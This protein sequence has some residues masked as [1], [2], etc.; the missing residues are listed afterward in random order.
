MKTVRRILRYIKG[1]P[2][3]GLW[4]KSNGHLRIEDYCD[5]D[6]ASCVDDCRYMT[7]YCVRVRINLVAWRSK[8][9]DMVVRSSTEAEY[10]AMTLTLCEMM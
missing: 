5:V 4:F 1:S 8:K 10:R 6:W 9:Q 3:N 7:G 2:R